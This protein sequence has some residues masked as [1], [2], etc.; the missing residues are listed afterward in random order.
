MILMW[1]FV[2]SFAIAAPAWYLSIVALIILQCLQQPEKCF[3]FRSRIWCSPPIS[4]NVSP[5]VAI[6]REPLTMLGNDPKKTHLSTA[7]TYLMPEP[8]PN[9]LLLIWQNSMSKLHPSVQQELI[10]RRKYVQQSVCQILCTKL[11]RLF[12]ISKKRPSHRSL[13]GCPLLL[14]YCRCKKAEKPSEKQQRK[15]NNLTD[16]TFSHQKSRPWC[17]VW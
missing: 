7:H 8:K 9:S 16:T 5:N 6:A 4:R 12:S 11:L 3:K 13:A 15:H 10:K 14:Y 17:W 2:L 1:N